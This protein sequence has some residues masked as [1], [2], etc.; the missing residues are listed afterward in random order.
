VDKFDVLVR[1]D[2]DVLR[3][4]K[5]LEKQGCIVNALVDA[6]RGVCVVSI[7]H[8][9]D[10]SRNNIGT[11]YCAP[12]DVFEPSV[13]LAIAFYRA[14]KKEVPN[15]FIYT[16]F[17][18][19]D[20]IED[21]LDAIHERD[22]RYGKFRDYHFK[23]VGDLQTEVARLKGELTQPPVAEDAIPAVQPAPEQVVPVTTV[24]T[25]TA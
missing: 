9:T 22:V 21:L 7:S 4:Q 2:N 23:V 12:G 15:C 10:T 13:G 17:D 24:T 16:R 8:P 19:E 3:F 18:D 25:E 6:D 20:E 14:M 5:R 1:A 11:A